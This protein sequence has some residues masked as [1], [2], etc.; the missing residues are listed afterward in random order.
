MV[1]RPTA[2]GHGVNPDSC[3]LCVAQRGEPICMCQITRG[4][5]DRKG[6]SENPASTVGN[7]CELQPRSADPSRLKILKWIILSL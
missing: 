2:H 5:T 4:K 6:R 1:F 3:S 7:T